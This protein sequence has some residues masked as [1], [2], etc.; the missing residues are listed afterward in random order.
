M[1]IYGQSQILSGRKHI[2]LNDRI[3]NLKSAASTFKNDSLISATSSL[4]RKSGE[5]NRQFIRSFTG[6]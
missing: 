2:F 1:P 6:R 5:I 4:L 3:E